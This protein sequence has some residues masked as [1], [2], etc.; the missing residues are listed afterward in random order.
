MRIAYICADPGVPVFGQKGCSIH[1]QEILR[2]LLKL[3]HQVSLFA[4]R[5]GDEPPADLAKIDVY[6]LPPIPKGEQSM[7]EKVA[8]AVNPDLKLELELAGSFDLIYERYS[9]WSYSGM[10]YAQ[11]KGI[12]GILEVNAPLIEEQAKHRG[13]IYRNSAEG[14][15]QR[16]FTAASQI[17]A[18][19]APIKNYLT[20][21]VNPEKVHVIPN[22][23]N[24]ERFASTLLPTFPNNSE[25]FVV[26]FVGSL[27]PWHGLAILT[28]AFT[29]LHQRVPQARLLIVGNGP[30]REKIEADLLARNLQSAV[31]FTGAVAPEQIPGLLASMNVAVAPYPEHTDFYFSPLKVYEYMAAGLPVVTSSI[32]QLT[33]LIEDGFNGILC[34]PGDARALANALEILWH[35]PELAISLGN[36]A[37]HHVLQHHTWDAIASQILTLANVNQLVGELR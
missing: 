29:R 32:G 19:S 1:V 15:A 16:V 8:L 4:I 30:E 24:C 23:V 28:D 9:L 33:E 7:R 25:T 22:G 13:L 34:P 21:Y 37:R 31:H 10:E 35:S 2:S 3:G 18:V 12:P 5:L 6:R 14:V 27:K 20:N 36:A 17:V 26:G 11:A